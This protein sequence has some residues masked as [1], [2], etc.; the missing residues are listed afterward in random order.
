MFILL[1]SSTNQELIEKYACNQ[2]NHYE[3]YDGA[4]RPSY[5][6]KLK[7]PLPFSISYV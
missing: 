6:L 3:K 2:D 7:Y 5:C 1:H 4:T